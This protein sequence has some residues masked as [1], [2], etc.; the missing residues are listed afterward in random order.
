MSKIKTLP[1][2]GNA[3]L[4]LNV[5]NDEALGSF[6]FK[7]FKIFDHKVL[8]SVVGVFGRKTE[9]FGLLLGLVE[10]V[11][12]RVL[13]G[14]LRV[15]RH[16]LENRGSCVADDEENHLVAFEVCCHVRF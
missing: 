10:R 1:V 3:S 16:R 11:E 4:I 15:L 5:V 13:E 14:T 9:L 2:I 8:F 12:G 6:N 7:I